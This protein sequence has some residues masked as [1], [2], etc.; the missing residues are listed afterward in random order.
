[1]IRDAAEAQQWAGGRL[2]QALYGAAAPVDGGMMQ[3]PQPQ[4]QPTT[5]TTGN[6]AGERG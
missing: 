5:T 3:Q 2:R 4:P 6:R 1:V